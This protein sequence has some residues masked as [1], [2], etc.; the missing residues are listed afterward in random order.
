[1]M[2]IVEKRCE[3]ATGAMKVKSQELLHMLGIMM[4]SA[5]PIQ[6]DQCFNSRHSGVPQTARDIEWV[7]IFHLEPFETAWRATLGLPEHTFLELLMENE[8]LRRIRSR[9]FDVSLYAAKLLTAGEWDK[10]EQGYQFGQCNIAKAVINSA[11]RIGAT[12]EL[13]KPR[14]ILMDSEQFKR[15]NQQLEDNP[16]SKNEAAQSLLKRPS[17]WAKPQ[18]ALTETELSTVGGAE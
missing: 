9:N 18:V 17:P 7:P 6:T 3:D 8:I 1:M 13:R 12:P 14:P 16:L 4:T 11:I 5:Y 2:S 15:F 10:L